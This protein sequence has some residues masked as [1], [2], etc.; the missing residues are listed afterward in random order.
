[1][2]PTLSWAFTRELA[3]CSWSCI[4]EESN[5]LILSIHSLCISSGRRVSVP[6]MYDAFHSVINADVR[7][8]VL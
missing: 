6:K 1:M 8:E 7:Y 3:T 5:M 4:Q 2:S